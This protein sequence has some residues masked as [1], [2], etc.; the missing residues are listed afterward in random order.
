MMERML[1]PSTAGME[2]MKEKRTANFRS[3]PTRQPVVMVVPERERPGQVAKA[4]E[5]PTMRASVIRALRSFFR[6]FLTRSL[7]NS[8]KPVR[9]RA[10]ATT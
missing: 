6:P 10:A 2:R 8:R 3:K 1:A 4:W 5:M 9:I 7:K